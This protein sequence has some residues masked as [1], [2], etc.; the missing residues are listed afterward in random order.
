MNLPGGLTW[1][2]VEPNGGSIAMDGTYTAPDVLGIFTIKASSTADVEC[3][4]TL[5]QSRNNKW[6]EQFECHVLWQTTFVER[7][8]WT[9]YDDGAARVVYALTKKVLA[10]VA[11]FALEIICERFESAAATTEDAENTR[12]ATHRV[13]EKCVDCFL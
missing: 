3:K 11:V 5:Q 13:V 10:Q 9:N 8:V 7:E 12:A 2:V 6:T 1:S 4:L